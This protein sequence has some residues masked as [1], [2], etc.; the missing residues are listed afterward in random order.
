MGGV[1]AI[2]TVYDFCAELIARH[3]EEKERKGRKKRRK[4]FTKGPILLYN[5][6][7][8][9]KNIKLFFI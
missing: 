3:A 4:Q 1:L 9:N 2:Y 5:I 7:V 8:K 6:I